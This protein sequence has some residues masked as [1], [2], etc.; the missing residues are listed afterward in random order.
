MEGEIMS[1]YAELKEA[2]AN[3]ILKEIA[4]LAPG[5]SES[6]IKDL[7]EAY[8]FVAGQKTPNPGTVQRLR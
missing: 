4:R 7:A 3:A 8:A 5:G 2:A 6:M 1:E